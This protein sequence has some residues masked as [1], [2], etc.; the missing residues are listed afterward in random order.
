MTTASRLKI[1]T[2]LA[3]ITSRG[4][5][6]GV[7]RGR[8]QVQVARPRRLLDDP[9]HRNTGRSNITTNGLFNADFK[10]RRHPQ[11]LGRGADQNA[12]VAQPHHRSA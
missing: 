3:I 10:W 12:S 2:S 9:V 11:V 7:V 8:A 5:N 6:L 1:I 4:V